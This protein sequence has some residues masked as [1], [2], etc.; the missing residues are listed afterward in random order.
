MLAW[1]T[2]LILFLWIWLN[3]WLLIHYIYRGRKTQLRR[4]FQRCRNGCQGHQVYLWQDSVL[5]F[6]SEI[7]SV[8]YFYFNSDV[9]PII[10]D[11]TLGNASAS[12]YVDLESTETWLADY[13]ND[14]EMDISPEELY[15]SLDHWFVL[16]IWL[17]KVTWQL[18]YLTQEFFSGRRC[19][20]WWW[21]R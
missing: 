19:S 20:N 10:I 11:F 1:S 15:A 9:S 12:D 14:A 3:L 21:Y 13:F 17:Y 5:W 7:S 2:I 16:K 6:Y 4:F 8:I 18:C